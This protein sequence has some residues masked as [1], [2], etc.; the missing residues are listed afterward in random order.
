MAA[1]DPVDGA[2][3]DNGEQQ[4]ADQDDGDDARE[5]AERVES[6]NRPLGDGGGD[7]AD[8]VSG[9]EHARQP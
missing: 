2:E 4:P 7:P 1:D 5:Q 6:H 3:A 8:D 9:Q